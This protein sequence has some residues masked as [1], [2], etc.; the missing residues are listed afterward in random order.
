MWKTTIS[1][2]T[3]L[4]TA[5]TTPTPRARIVI[6]DIRTVA[7]NVLSSAGF[8]VDLPFAPGSPVKSLQTDGDAHFGTAVPA[9]HTLPF[10]EALDWLLDH[11]IMLIIVPPWLQRCG[12]INW[13]TT[14]AAYADTRLYI[15]ELLSRERAQGPSKA[16]KNL[17]GAL[18]ATSDS[19]AKNEQLSER[20]LVGNVFVFAI[21]GLETTAGTL[22]YALTQLALHRDLQEWLWTDLDAALDGESEDPMEWDYNI[23]WPKLVAPLCIIVRPPLLCLLHQTAN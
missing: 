22:Q 18:V 12:P 16:K 20:D 19:A 14:A 21:A 8:G 7:R 5:W 4:L 3:C 11:V 6:Q 13:R 17:L 1:Q 10:G 23:V 9:G 15:S 2:A